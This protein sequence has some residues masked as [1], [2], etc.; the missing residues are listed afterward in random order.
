MSIEQE[1]W[2]TIS[3]KDY[4]STIDV[5]KSDEEGTFQVDTF[6]NPTTKKSVTLEAADGG[7]LELIKYLIDQRNVDP[8]QKHQKNGVT[9]LHLA[10]RGKH[11]SIVEYLLTQSSIDVN[12]QDRDEYTALH[13]AAL[14]GA[15]DIVQLLIARHDTKVDIV[16]YQQRTPLMRA[17]EQC[18]TD[19]AHELI[20]KAKAKVN[21]QNNHGWTA[22]HYASYNQRKIICE[23]LL[24]HGAVSTIKDREGHQALYWGYGHW[25]NEDNP[26]ACACPHH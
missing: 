11:T 7:C 10:A 4:L 9:S 2:N 22:L 21:I 1:V 23:M 25:F 14:N 5:L 15:K 6:L 24:K 26:Y 8:N 18:F 3:R 12:A 19:V 20:V 13:Y 17:V 16:D